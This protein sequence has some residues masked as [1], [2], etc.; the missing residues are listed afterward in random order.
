MRSRLLLHKPFLFIPLLSEEGCLGW[1][2]RGGVK[3]LGEEE[4][5]LTDEENLTQENYAQV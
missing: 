2:G 5:K 4:L 1:P 3:T